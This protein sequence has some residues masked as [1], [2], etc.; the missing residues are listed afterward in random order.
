[1]HELR[2]LSISMATLSLCL[3]SKEKHHQEYEWQI[4]ILYPHVGR[5]RDGVTNM[6][7]VI[8]EINIFLV[9]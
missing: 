1:M 2:D 8:L 4:S 6:K 5:K 9:A 3:P 7:A